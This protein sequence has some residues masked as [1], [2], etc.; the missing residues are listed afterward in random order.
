MENT[1]PFKLIVPRRPVAGKGRAKN[2]KYADSM[3]KAA[4]ERITAPLARDARLYCRSFGF[5][6][7]QLN[8][9]WTTFVGPIIDA[10]KG[11]P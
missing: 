6:G 2:K 3:Q 7:G 11:S 9:T 4:A 5:I 10:L 8:R 1:D